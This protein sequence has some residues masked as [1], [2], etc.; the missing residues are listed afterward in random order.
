MAHAARILLINNHPAPSPLETLHFTRR[1]CD[2]RVEADP[3][4]AVQH[5]YDL[6]PDVIV[7]DV[8]LPGVRLADL[9]ARL[10]EESVVPILVLSADLT[11]EFALRAFEAGVDECIPKTVTLQFLEARMKVWCRRIWSIPLNIVEPLRLGEVRLDPSERTFTLNRSEPV[12]LTHLETRLLYCL[13]GK[14]G[15]PFTV[16]ELCRRIWGDNPAGNK[17]TLKNTIYRLRQKIEP[18]SMQPRFIQTV[19]GGGYRFGSA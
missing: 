17:E 19:P 6:T 13:M 12:R 18:D 14:P 4:R 10:R 16:E 3:A 7:F 5:W 2:L 11:E 1:N 9:V 8:D 15:R